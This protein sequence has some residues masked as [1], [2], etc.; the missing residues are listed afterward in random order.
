MR[1]AEQEG[2]PERAPEYEREMRERDRRDR[3]RSIAPLS[4]AAG[5]LELNSDDLTLEQVVTSILGA[6]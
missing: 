6:L 5:A 2:H 4:L 3:E 1:R